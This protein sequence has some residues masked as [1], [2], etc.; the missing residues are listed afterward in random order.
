[1]ASQSPNLQEVKSRMK[2]AWMAGD[3]GKIASMNRE[4]G[5]NFVARLNLQSGMKVLDV[6]CGTGNQSIPAAR[7]GAQVTGLDIAPNLLAQA[8]ARA[9]EEK[10]PIEFIEG[11]AEELPF[12][13][14]SFDAVFSMF[15]A[16]F[17]PR[18]ER[19]AAELKRITR[20]GGLI[21]MANWTPTSV[22]GQL[23][24]VTARHAPPPPGM[25]PPYRWGID[26]VVRERFG[27]DLDLETRTITELFEFDEDPAGVVQLF[28]NYFGPVKTTFDRL[29]P[30]SQQRLAWDLEQVFAAL[31][32]S[33]TGGTKEDAEFLE[34]HARK[35]TT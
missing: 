35:R 1:M 24:A 28:R 3:F 10:L 31:N 17:A 18:P 12:D 30:E 7:A 25:Q 6:A 14:A 19:V 26:E 33:T 34:V 20:P 27:R 9:A 4:W 32:A 2:A 5:E 16:M 15:G 21:S 13:D 23:F 29:D 22:P 11:D 8:K